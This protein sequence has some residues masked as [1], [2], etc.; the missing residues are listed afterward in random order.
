MAAAEDAVA[1]A[2]VH[3]HNLPGLG[4]YASPEAGA[5][6]IPRRSESL[7]GLCGPRAVWY[8]DRTAR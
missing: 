1:I 4:R 6:A 5:E 3:L 8:T 2:P 7:G